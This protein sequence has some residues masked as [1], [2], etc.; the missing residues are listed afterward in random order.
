MSEPPE[1]PRKSYSEAMNEWASTRE[2]QMVLMSKSRNRLL[3]P[4]PL[5]GTVSVIFGYLF[6][7]IALALLGFA[8]YLLAVRFHI[9]G[10]EF[11]DQ[12]G[13]ELGRYLKADHLTLSNLAFVEGWG[14]VK[15]TTAEGG[16]DAPFK[17]LE[18]NGLDM[19]I[20]YLMLWK[21]DWTINRVKI[22]ELSATIRSGS[23]GAAPD[24]HLDELDRM[25]LPDGVTT[26][27]ESSEPIRAPEIKKG[28]AVPP[29]QSVRHAGLGVSPVF[30]SLKL[31]N[32]NIGKTSLFWGLTAG[33]A[34]RLED[35]TVEM[36]TE[37]NQTWHLSATSGS[38]TQN[39]LDRMKIERMEA[40]LAPA[41]LTF[42]PGRLSVGGAPCTLNGSIKTGA[43]PVLN[44]KFTCEK[45]PVAK[46][47]EPVAAQSFDLLVTGEAAFEGALNSPAGV[48]SS[49][50]FKIESGTIR[51]LPVLD[52]LAVVTGRPRFR[53]FDVTGGQIAF[54]VQN[55]VVSVSDFSLESGAEVKVTGNF[56]WDNGVI[57]GT[58]SV[59][60]TKPY[61][62]RVPS[63]LLA[64]RAQE[65]DGGWLWLTFPLDGRME[66]LTMDH[67]SALIKDY[68][69]TIKK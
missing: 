3:R 27:V 34:G 19:D 36:N 28:A 68:N 6:R 15:K 35:A 22:R 57:K 17:R 33:T 60:M 21:K 5:G 43:S 26:P 69:E 7:L 18:I 44:L 65:K 47:L 53:T 23:A 42:G 40:T 49:G 41:E 30:D 66:K 11:R 50:A 16:P 8:V 58:Y 63:E 39:W 12:I 1:K 25:T 54:K 56:T 55:G 51:T 20:P 14:V 32:I 59:G 61:A 9:R 31:R 38:L 48:A 10:N 67:R 2:A 4:D 13:R 29:P 52:A 45:M 62:Q 46:F 24:I 37:D 64:A